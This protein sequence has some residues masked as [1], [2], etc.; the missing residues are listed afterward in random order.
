LGTKCAFCI[1]TGTGW[2]LVPGGL[3]RQPIC[4]VNFCPVGY[5]FTS[6][7]KNII[8]TKH[9][10]EAISNRELS[11]SEIF[12]RGVGL[13]NDT[14]DYETKGVDLN[15]NTPK[16]IRDVAIEMAERLADTWQ[17][18]PDDEALQQRFWELFPTDAVDVSAGN[19]FHGEIR[20]R[21]GAAFLRNNP[22]WL[23]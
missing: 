18:H 16:E 3:F 12:A 13:I 6:S 20:A 22:K 10:V 5:L 21:F 14:S 17:A 15:E 8:L 19:R 7:E 11:L 4:F 23:Q 2:D 9:H 1:S